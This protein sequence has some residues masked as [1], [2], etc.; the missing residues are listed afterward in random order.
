MS[1]AKRDEVV[2]RAGTDRVIAV[3]SSD[4]VVAAPGRD[5]EILDAIESDAVPGGTEQGPL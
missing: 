2:A 5:R 3:A 4:I 1:E